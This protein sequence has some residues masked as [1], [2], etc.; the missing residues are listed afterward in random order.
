MLKACASRELDVPI[1]YRGRIGR[2]GLFPTDRANSQ[3]S[4][5]LCTFTDPL[6]HFLSLQSRA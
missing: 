2:E 1:A 4:G 3:D 5:E 6:A